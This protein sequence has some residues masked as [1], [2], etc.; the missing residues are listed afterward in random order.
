MP[1]VPRRL[2]SLIKD[3]APRPGCVVENPMLASQGYGLT[4]FS[5]G[6]RTS[7]PAERQKRP[8]LYI[9]IS[10]EV[11]IEIHDRQ[12][13]RTVVLHEGEVFIRHAGVLIGFRAQQDCIF[14]EQSFRD[15]VSFVEEIYFREIMKLDEWVAL[16]GKDA[17]RTILD[18]WA[19]FGNVYGFPAGTEFDHQVR[20]GVV[21]FICLEG[22]IELETDNGRILVMKPWDAVFLHP[23]RYHHLHVKTTEDT[24]AMR[25]WKLY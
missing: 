7:T 12:P 8:S 5:M 10:G 19:L 23:H 9:V 20:K 2:F 13:F 11:D 16:T 1:E 21:M 17:Y 24:R 22:R 25:L 15:S 18:G 4:F 6:E 14:L 3:N